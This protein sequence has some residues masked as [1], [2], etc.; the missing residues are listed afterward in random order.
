MYSRYSAASLPCEKTIA[1]LPGWVS[2]SLVSFILGKYDYIANSTT[3]QSA[4]AI[5]GTKMLISIFPAV[6]FLVAVGLLF[7]Y[8]IDKKKEVEIEN[9]LK[10][11][12]AE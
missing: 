1:I 5:N 6:P 12:R 9:A 3:G 8:E 7:F 2:R 4:I 10:A 11:R